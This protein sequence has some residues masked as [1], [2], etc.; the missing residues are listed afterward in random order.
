MSG[1][2]SH[3]FDAHY[4][5][6]GCGMPYERTPAWLNFFG[7][8]ADRIVRDIGPKT[9]LDAGCAL[10]FLVEMLRERGIE[11][12]GVDISEYAI[13]NVH[14]RIQPYCRIGSISEPFANYDLPER[15]DLIVNIEV[16]EHMQPR[17]AEQ[18]AANLC[19]HADD[20]LFSSTPFDY[21]EATHFHVQ[22]PEYWAELFSHQGFYRDVDFDASFITQWAVRFRH[23][24]EPAHRLVRD[25][26]RKFWLLWK[27]NCDLRALN[28]ESR[29][30][31]AG[32]DA[33]IMQQS[34]QAVERE[35]RLSAIQNENSLHQEALSQELATWRDLAERYEAGRFMRFMRWLNSIRK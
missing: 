1:D 30:L 3:H 8:L 2:E 35:D 29:N 14:E 22:P 9:V 5:A 32:Q 15:Y 19:A 17:D 7:G 31:L 4:Y 11:A 28:L 12:Y 26:E 20:I 21:K 6:T 33:Q 10:G 27:E 18:A 25:Y 24:Q 16:L 34:E 13:R 23:S